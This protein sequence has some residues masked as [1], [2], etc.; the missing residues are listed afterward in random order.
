MA[1][2]K[3]KNPSKGLVAAAGNKKAC[4]CKP[5]LSNYPSV[6]PAKRRSVKRMMFDSM[7][8]SLASCFH[9]WSS[10]SS[11]DSKSNKKTTS[12]IFSDQS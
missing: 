6:I 8:K 3:K 7:L 9:R 12:L 2:T 11:Q 1:T 4:F 10:S 5:N